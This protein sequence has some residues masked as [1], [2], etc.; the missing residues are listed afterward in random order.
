MSFSRRLVGDRFH[1]IVQREGA[2]E[3]AEVVG[4]PV[5]LEANGIVVIPKKQPGKFR[6]LGIS[7]IPMNNLSSCRS[8]L[9]LNCIGDAVRL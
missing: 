4:K 8:T 9:C 3:V 5:K 2:H 7:C 6:P 1:G